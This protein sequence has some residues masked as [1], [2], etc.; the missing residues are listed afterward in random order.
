MRPDRRTLK[1]IAIVLVWAGLAR[2][3]ILHW[4]P[5]PATLDGFF[6]LRS[7]ELLSA[8]GTIPTPIDWDRVVMTAF[9]GSVREVLGVK[10]LTLLQPLSAVLGLAPVLV[11]IVLVRRLAIAVH[12]LSSGQTRVAVA[13]TG[14]VLAIEGLFVRRSG[15]PDEE[16]LGLLFVPLVAYTFHR[17]L[18]TERWRWAVP[19]VVLLVVLPATHS[20]STTVTLFTIGVITIVHTAAGWR[21]SVGLRAAGGLLFG[22]ACALGYY[23]LAT[24]APTLTLSYADRLLSQPRLLG[25]WIVLLAAG[26]VWFV[27][28]SARIQRVIVGGVL[29]SWIGV[30]AANL[31]QPVYVGTIPTPPLVLA[32]VMPLTGLIAAAALG[33]DRVANRDAR[34]TAVLGLFVAP[35]VLVNYFLTAGL[36]PDLF[37]AILRVQT[38]V[39]LPAAAI[40]GTFVATRF[41]GVA[42]AGVRW[43]RWG[44][45]A[46]AVV[47]LGAVVTAPLGVMAL[48]TATV[49]GTT[50]PKAFAG[51]GF[52]ATHV[53]GT[54]AS[55]DQVQRVSGLYY[56]HSAGV[57]PVARWAR[58]GNA[59][60][61]PV[62]ATPAWT[63]RGIHQYPRPPAR[64]D[65]DR[66]VAWRAE[67]GVVY[68][69]GR[70]DDRD[71]YLLVVPVE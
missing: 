37:D 5:Y 41:T 13:L 70:S 31:A 59:P 62:V 3:A 60:Q 69:T 28:T 55:D 10:A 7:L 16:L 63:D 52:A 2:G 51:A 53:T 39:H 57:E 11:G 19:S 4:S 64:V 27:R 67:R 61:V 33:I 38:F 14:G 20:L 43:R 58:G 26:V 21:L 22:L 18:R 12:G 36:S 47:L 49:P 56:D 66:F 48:D 71:H 44:R 8:S 25:A 54:W 24:T 35:I 32:L 29:L 30:L 50:T 65:A 17:W 42:G 15:V 46:F 34:G 9:L 6:H 45:A 23:W 68:T 1:V 40:A